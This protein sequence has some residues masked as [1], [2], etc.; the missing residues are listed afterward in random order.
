MQGLVVSIVGIL[1]CIVALCSATYAWFSGDVQS[2][3]NNIKAGHFGIEVVSIVRDDDGEVSLAAESTILPDA[4]G[5]Y[6]LGEGKYTITLRPMEESTVK[7]YC[8]VTVN[9]IEFS[10]DV[11]VSDNTVSES[12]P[13]PNSPFVF[14][15]EV[16]EE[17][18]VLFDSKWG[19]PAFPTI[20]NGETL[21]TDLPPFA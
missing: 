6:V 20:V 3:S 17:A 2:N 5:S 9:G 18:T 19:I 1:I 11:I 10:T 7:G 15:I 13:T 21:D 4:S 8:V 16:A 14:Y 12:Y